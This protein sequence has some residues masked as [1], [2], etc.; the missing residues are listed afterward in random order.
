MSTSRM[1]P[2]T[3]HV[4]GDEI[5]VYFN[6]SLYR[7]VDDFEPQEDDVIQVTFPRSGTHWAQQ[8]IQLVVHRGKSA[9]SFSE[10]TERAPFLEMQGLKMTSKPRLLRSHLPI[11]KVPFNP[12]AKYVYVAWSCVSK[13]ALKHLKD[14]LDFSG[15]EIKLTA[16]KSVIL[17]TF[18][19]ASPV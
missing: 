15:Q 16:Y 6:P 4:D 1:L 13:E 14:G 12:R 19:Y 8:I 18:E 2:D 3:Q 17:Q 11:G 7:A 5:C 9:S 10:F